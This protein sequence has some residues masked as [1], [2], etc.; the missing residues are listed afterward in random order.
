[1]WRAYVAM[2]RHLDEALE[3]QLHDDSNLSLGDYVLLMRLSEAPGR[4]LRMSELAA[5]TVY[6]RSRLSHAVRRLE[7]LGWVAR[8]ECPDDRRGTFARLTDAGFAVLADAAPGHATAVHDLI[9]EPL[10]AAGTAELG[11]LVRAIQDNLDE[12]DVR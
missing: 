1:M 5:D 11:R 3:R 6:S 2:V 8:D 4:Q 12:R 10:G 9:F 7:E